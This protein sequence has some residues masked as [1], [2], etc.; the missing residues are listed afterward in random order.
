MVEAS[1]NDLFSE[2]PYDSLKS[3]GKRQKLIKCVLTRNSKQYLDKA[4]IEEQVNELS[5]EEVHG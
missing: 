4:S 3:D 5:E 1:I 2:V